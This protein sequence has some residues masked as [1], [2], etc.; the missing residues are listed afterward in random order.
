M[1]LAGYKRY[2]GGIPRGQLK[3]LVPYNGTGVYQEPVPPHSVP[4]GVAIADAVVRLA[5]SGGLSARVSRS[6]LSAALRC[7]FMI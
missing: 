4:P 7:C 2:A 5:T 3:S 6:L 1:K